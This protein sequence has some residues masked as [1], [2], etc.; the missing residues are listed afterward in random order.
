MNEIRARISEMPQRRILI[1]ND[2]EMINPSHDKLVSNCN[3][4]HNYQTVDI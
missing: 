4:A 1:E 3:R 2:D